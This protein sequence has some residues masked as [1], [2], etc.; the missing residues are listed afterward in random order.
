[1]TQS[2]ARSQ[3][4]FSRLYIQLIIAI[5]LGILVGLFLPHLSPGHRA[6]TE[7]ALQ[8][9]STGFIKVIRMVLAPII[10][11]T[12]VVGIAKMGEIKSVGRVGFKAIVYFEIVSTFALVIGLTV[13]NLAQPGRGMNIT[14]ASLDV[15]RISQFTSA[16]KNLTVLDFI[17]NII[18]GSAAGAFVEGNMLQVILVSLLFG[19]SLSMVKGKKQVMIEWLE[20]FLHVMFGIVRFVMHL[21]PLAAF[22]SIS[23]VVSKYGVHSLGNFGKLLACDYGTSLLF[24]FIVLQIVTYFS[25]ISLWKFLGYIKTEILIVF[26]TNSTETV[27]P[28]MLAKMEYLG[29]EESVVGLV[30][31]A[32]YTFNADGTSIYLTMAAIFIAQAMNIHLSLGDQLLILGVLLLTSKGSAGVAGAGFITLAATLSSMNGKIPVS[33]IVLLLGIESLINQA[34]AVTNLIGNGIAT[35]A[36]ARW[37]NAFDVERAKSVLNKTIDDTDKIVASV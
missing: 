2:H 31:P 24:I 25:G 13:V 23:V 11:G 36:V 15:S 10:F 28:Q 5:F 1:M 16:A 21:A 17:L 7:S 12:V 32:G 3:S 33:G 37:E 29:C 19:I 27:L 18:P 20:S 22:G 30:L 8:A 6:D 4:I 35:V 26:A 9:L 14:P 34:R